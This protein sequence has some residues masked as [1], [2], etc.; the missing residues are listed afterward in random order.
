MSDQ[1]E[2]ESV[3]VGQHP[4][5]GP[6]AADIAA[7]WRR[8]AVSPWRWRLCDSQAGVVDGYKEGEAGGL[9]VTCDEVPRRAYLKPTRRERGPFTNRAAREKIVA[10]L[11]WDLGVNVPPVLLFRREGMTGDRESLCSVSLVMCKRQFPWLTVK[12]LIVDA[13]DDDARALI[14]KDLPI[15]AA[16]AMALDAWVMQFDHNDHPHNIVMG[17]SGPDQASLIFLDYALSLGHAWTHTEAFKSIGWRRWNDDEKG[18]LAAVPTLFPPHLVRFLH[19][20][21]LWATVEK[22]E[23]FP[24][25][26]I[27]DVVGRIP[28]DYLTDLERDTLVKGLIERRSV[29]RGPLEAQIPPQRGDA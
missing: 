21:E 9:F 2:E 29:I 3:D 16:R 1:V 24:E 17:I 10:D 5:P 13:A 11:A 6:E 18:W 25:D 7:T 14:M 12:R 23:S 4:H 15:A 26:V 19:R 8:E 28:S 27:R 20:D 22:I